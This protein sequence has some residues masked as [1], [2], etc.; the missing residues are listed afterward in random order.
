[1][2]NDT[3]QFNKVSKENE[4]YCKRNDLK[5]HYYFAQ[6]NQRDISGILKNSKKNNQLK[7][8]IEQI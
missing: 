4:E 6:S 2:P 3:E 7:V 1:M 8:R 5:F